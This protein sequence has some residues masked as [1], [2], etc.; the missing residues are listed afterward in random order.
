MG[1]LRRKRP[2]LF[3]KR[4]AMTRRRFSEREVLATLI[5]QGVTVP[6]YRTKEPFT[7]ETVRRAEREH[8]VE[9]GLVKPEDRAK[10]DTPE[11]CRYSLK[12]AHAI[13][14]NGTKATTA[15]SSKHRIA[16]AD[17]LEKARLGEDQKPKHRLQG[18]RVLRGQ[19]FPE[20][21]PGYVKNWPSRG[22]GKRGKENG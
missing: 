18:G 7:L 15:G 14:T 19:G 2:I 6:C 22:F 17:R 3:G 10:Y 5:H 20:P 9:L 11:Y 21:P 16:K 4:S 13:V 12:E 8:L 1:R